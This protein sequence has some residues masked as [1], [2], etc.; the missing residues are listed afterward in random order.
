MLEMNI[1][2]TKNVYTAWYYSV[3]NYIAFDPPFC[4]LPHFLLGSAAQNMSH[5]I[6]IPE[7]KCHPNLALG[8]ILL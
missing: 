4:H 1:C 6:Q 3:T 5:C 2:L 8:K 7:L